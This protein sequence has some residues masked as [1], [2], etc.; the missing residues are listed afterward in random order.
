ME[1]TQVVEASSRYICF[2]WIDSFFY[3]IQQYLRPLKSYFNIQ[4]PV[5]R[6][7]FQMPIDIPELA[8]A[9][10]QFDIQLTIHIGNYI[11]Y[12]TPDVCHY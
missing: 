3:V 7:Q 6:C 5:D 11:I 10:W 12:T 9:N 4:M 8:A 1:G 2:Q